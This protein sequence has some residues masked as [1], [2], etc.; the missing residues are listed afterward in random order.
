MSWPRS[1][2]SQPGSHLISNLFP[3]W[4]STMECLSK[5]LNFF[6][7][8]GHCGLARARIPGNSQIIT[9]LGLRQI[10]SKTSDN[11][12]AYCGGVVKVRSEYPGTY[13]CEGMAGLIPPRGLARSL[14]VG[15][16]LGILTLALLAH[17]EVRGTRYVQSLLCAF[18]LQ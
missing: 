17:F 1:H 6:N 18:A 7:T 5:G 9:K 15:Q 8:T 14:I 10:N 3:D 4:L 13:F 12:R 11:R 2:H 16:N